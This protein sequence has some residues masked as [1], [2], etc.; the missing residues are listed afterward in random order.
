MTHT[1]PAPD[2]RQRV[3]VETPEHVT[4]DLEIA[5]VGSRVLAG[6]IDTAILAGLT[7][8][9][10]LLLLL[11]AEAGAIPTGEG[12]A[13]APLAPPTALDHHTHGLLYLITLLLI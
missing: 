4:L 8:V 3:E 7:L 5:G 2:Y 1:G 13:P 9:V 10:G 6:A 12:T 11:L